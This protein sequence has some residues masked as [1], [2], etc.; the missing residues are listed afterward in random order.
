VAPGFVCPGKSHSFIATGAASFSWTGNGLDSLAGSVVTST[1]PISTGYTITGYNAGCYSAAQTTSLVVLP[2]PT[3]SVS[4]ETST[5]CLGTSTLLSGI[6]SATSFT[7]YP[8]SA[9]N[10]QTAQ[11]VLATPSSVQ[12]Y[13]V[14]GALNGCTNVATATI[15]VMHPPLV[16]MSVSRPAI[17][18]ANYN[19]SVNSLSI[20]ATG[21]AQYTLLPHTYFTVSQPNGP[22]MQVTAS[23]VTTGSAI[24]ATAS[25]VGVTGVCTVLKTHTFLIIPNPVISVSPSGSSI[26]PG[27]EQV[28][29]LSGAA[30]YTWLNSVTLNTLTATSAVAKPQQTSFYSVTGASLGCL[31]ESK[32][33]V[34]VV[35]PQPALTAS[36]ET[37]TLCVG[38]SI[39]LSAQGTGTSY[40]WMPFADL[41]AP[42]GGTVVAKPLVSRDYT[43]VSTLNTCT[44]QAVVTLSAIP[45]PKINAWTDHPVICSS[46][47]T[48][49]RATG[50]W[51]FSWSPTE[52]L[53]GSTGNLVTAFPPV[54]TTFTV[55]GFNGTCSG[56]TSVY[57]ETVKRPDFRI[58][59]KDG[60]NVMCYG[61]SV[62]VETA[63]AEN[64][65]WS[66]SQFVQPISSN[67]MVALNPPV[68][69]NFVI[70]AS[71]SK[72]SVT[73]Q[74]QSGFSVTVV[75]EIKPVVSANISLCDGDKTTL[76]AGGGNT[77]KWS[78]EDG[79][80]QGNG[81]RV[82]ANP[83]VSTLYTVEISYHTFCAKNATVLVQVNPRPAVY[84]GRDTAYQIND[85]IFLGAAGTG[86]LS[87]VSGDGILCR[88]C[89][90]TQVLPAR[91]GCYLVEAVNE[92]GCTNHDEVCLEITEDFTFYIPNAF[93][94]NHD[95]L[96][97]AFM[98]YG[99]NIYDLSME[100]YDR[101]G[102]LLFR[103]HGE[104]LRW[105]GTFHGAECKPDS[106]TY[107]ISYT[108]LNRKKYD[109]TGHVTLTR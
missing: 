83:S 35:L 34:L 11:Q 64:Y 97:D 84:A 9:V 91:S 88:D 23:T 101:W 109:L 38:Q 93:T 67:T 65:V 58:T 31:S 63:G 75:P 39:V 29:H 90:N 52:H 50:A 28:F 42:M 26:C 46:A 45:M 66:P 62:T 4:P 57:V 95:G 99:E 18:A 87:W 100:I 89:P 79:L 54:N 59:S 5:I 40:L 92:H 37:S 73:C 48:F 60:Q 41:S 80:N 20:T 53:N 74:Q 81:N 25:L 85:A 21:A 51:T 33:A 49:L 10:S 56:S 32:N 102:H 108:G 86:T 61:S 13:S 22:V 76:V 44:A 14:I 2:V 1:S 30:T 106:Y 71:N 72:G 94:P 24:T 77:F 68:S 69:T 55:W 7:W 16:K 70:I 8:Q 103:S 104:N 43:V 27:Q 19:N 105:D 78:P 82:V 12:V 36:P 47:N 98:I 6:G 17:C 96:N 15:N 3:L 107:R